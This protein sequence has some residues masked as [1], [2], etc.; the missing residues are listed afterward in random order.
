MACLQ[1]WQPPEYMFVL[2]SVAGYGTMCLQVASYSEAP[3]LP[4]EAALC[5]SDATPSSRFAQENNASYPLPRVQPCVGVQYVHRHSKG[6]E[7]ERLSC[8]NVRSGLTFSC[9]WVTL[10]SCAVASGWQV[11]SAGHRVSSPSGGKN[12]SFIDLLSLS[13]NFFW[14][15]SI[16]INF[17]S[18]RSGSFSIREQ[19]PISPVAKNSPSQF[20]AFSI[21]HKHQQ[22]STTSLLISILND[23]SAN[24]HRHFWWQARIPSQED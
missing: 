6:E 9:V 24:K 17:F 5:T 16:L 12:W 1:V 20:Q 13:G 8:E 11:Y 3:L 19:G 18:P 15:C 21:S 2:S 7:D 14:S 22:T 23:A 4:Y 10:S